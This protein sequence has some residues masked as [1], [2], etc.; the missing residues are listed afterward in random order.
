MQVKAALCAALYPNAVVK[1]ESA[2]K[3]ARLAWN[4]GVADVYIHPSSI[5]HPLEAQQFLRPYLVYLE[6]VS[7]P[8]SALSGLHMPI[9]RI[10]I[11]LQ[12][13]S[14]C[15]AIERTRLLFFSRRRLTHDC[16]NTRLLTK[17]KDMLCTVLLL[18]GEAWSAVH[19]TGDTLNGQQVALFCHVAM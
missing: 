18:S 13:C 3:S 17:W 11:M 16:F 6:K 5:N 8:H 4:D 10:Y 12:S 2:G 9:I 7:L 15:G 19:A 1:D 14:Q